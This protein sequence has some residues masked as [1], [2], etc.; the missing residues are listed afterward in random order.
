MSVDEHIES[1]TTELSFLSV[2]EF[3]RKIAI[4]TE[5]VFHNSKMNRI[6]RIKLAEFSYKRVM[7]S[8]Q[9]LELDISLCWG[10]IFF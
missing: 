2:H 6:C 10:L 7:D 5:I 3:A 4:C 1:S 8:T 9:H